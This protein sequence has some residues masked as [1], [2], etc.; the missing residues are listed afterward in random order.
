[1]FSHLR[2]DYRKL[3]RPICG[4]RAEPICAERVRTYSFF[5]ASRV[6]R[7]PSREK[8]DTSREKRDASRNKRDASL[9]K[10]DTS[11]ETV[12]TYL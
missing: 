8:R 2:H 11:H 10:R 4:T 7:D 12:V 3:D 1:M 5:T 6:K 9:E